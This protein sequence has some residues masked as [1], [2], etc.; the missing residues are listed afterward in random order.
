MNDFHKKLNKYAKLTVRVGI[1]LQKGQP[2]VITAPVEGAEFV[3]LVARNAYEIGASDVHINWND[4]TL[5]KLK[6]E[7]APMEVFEYFPKW[8]SDAMIDYAKRGAGFISI[9]AEDPELLK[10]MDPKK[11]AT[12]NKSSGIGMK[13]FRKYTMNDIN[14]WC[15]ISIP[16]KGWAKRVFKDVDEDTAV[17]MLWERIFKATRMDL[18][19]PVQ[20]WKDHIKT[21]EEK[22]TYLNNKSFKT[23]YYTSSNGTDLVI[24]LPEGHK[25]S[26]G[27][28]T[29][30]KG[31]FFVAN[32]P[33]EEVYTLPHKT[34]VNGVVY[35]TKPLNYGGNL[36]DD[37]KIVFKDGKVIDFEAK[38]GQDI[39][40]DLLDID[41]GARYLGEVAL[42]PHSSPISQANI[43]FFNTLF[44]ENAS[45]HLAFGKAYPTCI[46]GGEKMTD[47]ELE[48]LGVNN[49]LTHEDF[50]IGSEDL[51]IIGETLSRETIQI[52][53]NGEW[54]I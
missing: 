27:T 42:V 13:E 54:V 21:L 32:M 40:K 26:G 23:L 20:A 41:E 16:T 33:T 25:W 45:C 30:S 46:A 49:S 43:V 48:K 19:D 31:T 36:I 10:D 12:A 51:S 7:N 4:D 17:E 3:R 44:D 34:G 1:N 24:N 14:S 6:Y 5:T 18:D 50:M 39:L 28:G 52:F 37:F 53:K 35:S 38:I 11:I 29:N 9:H 2:L 47:E 15:V 8:K 22:V